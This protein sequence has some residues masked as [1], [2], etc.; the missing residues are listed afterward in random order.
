MRYMIYG[1]LLTV[2]SAALLVAY[3]WQS[4]GGGNEVSTSDYQSCELIKGPV[5]AEDI[6][7]GLGGYAYISADDRRAHLGNPAAAG[8]VYRFQSAGEKHELQLMELPEALNS[9]HPHGISYFKEADKEY[10]FVINHRV[11]AAADGGHDIFLFRIDGL[12]LITVKQ[13]VVPDGYS[14]NDIAAISSEEFYFSSDRKALSGIAMYVEVLLGL[15][16]SSIGHYYQGQ[17]KVAVDGLAFAN[18][19]AYSPRYQQLWVSESRAGQLGKYYRSEKGGLEL[20]QKFSLGNS[21]DNISVLENGDLLV[22][23]H[24]NGVAQARNASDSTIASPS[25]IWKVKANGKLDTPLLQLD[26]RAYSA[27]SVAVSIN[28]QLLLGS[29]YNDGLLLCSVEQ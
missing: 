25:R 15:A 17:W 20:L 1:L 6:E 9:F 16:R 28:N 26:G 8:N 18:G 24:V 4:L 5:G 21:P 14:P 11:P 3:I 22:A 29:I 27:A 13:L 19:I 12:R 23:D 10:L 7:V 2:V